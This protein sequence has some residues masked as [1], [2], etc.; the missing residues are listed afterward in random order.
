MPVCAGMTSTLI[1][2]RVAEGHDGETAIRAPGIA[3]AVVALERLVEA[4]EPLHRL[5]D[6]SLL[7]LFD[8][9]VALGIDIW[10]RCDG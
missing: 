10:A 8:Q 4:V 3:A 1:S 6:F 9:A 2:L 7:Q 5:N